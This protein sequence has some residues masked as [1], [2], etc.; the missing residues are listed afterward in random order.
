MIPKTRLKGH[1]TLYRQEPIKIPL[2]H[3]KFGSNRH[4]DTEDIVVLVYHVISHDHMIKES[5]DLINRSLQVKLPSCQ[6]WW[7]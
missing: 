1:L 5:P 7:G 2:H 3:A 4:S 6:V